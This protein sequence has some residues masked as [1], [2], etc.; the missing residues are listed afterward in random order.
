[1][2]RFTAAGASGIDTRWFGRR[3]SAYLAKRLAHASITHAIDATSESDRAKAAAPFADH[4]FPPGED[5]PLRGRTVT[6]AP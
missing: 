5:G 4:G 2:P 1:M 3:A 6:V